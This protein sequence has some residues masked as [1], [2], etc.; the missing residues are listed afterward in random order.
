MGHGLVALNQM[1]N[2]TIDSFI[3]HQQLLLQR[4]WCRCHCNPQPKT[5]L[6]LQ[7]HIMGKATTVTGITAGVKQLWAK[8]DQ[9]QIICLR[10]HMFPKHPLM[11]L[12]FSMIDLW[13]KATHLF[14]F[15]SF[16]LS[17]SKLSVFESRTDF[18]KRSEQHCEE[19]FYNPQPYCSRLYIPIVQNMIYCCKIVNC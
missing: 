16:L 19:Q 9:D 13:P 1:N 11:R 10:P 8:W 3:A 5:D 14:S 12:K 18:G 17:I 7:W 2:P 6:S 4:L 15:F